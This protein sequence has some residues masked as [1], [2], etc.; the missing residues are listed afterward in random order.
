MFSA[1]KGYFFS[2]SS[3][4]N[5]TTNSKENK[6]LKSDISNNNIIQNP[7]K[8]T[9]IKGEK[10]K[11]DFSDEY[12]EDENKQ[13][14]PSE[15][16]NNFIL[17]IDTV[18][19]W[20]M[21][22]CIYVK[23]SL[24]NITTLNCFK[25]IKIKKTKEGLLSYLGLG[26]ETLCEMKYIAAFDEHFIYMINLMK[27]ENKDEKDFMKVIG[28]HY[29]IMKINSVEISENKDRVLVS[30]LFV[31]DNDV[32]NFVSKTKK[33]YFEKQ[34]AFKFL[35]NLKDYL[36]NY[37]IKITYNDKVFKNIKFN[38]IEQK[39]E[40]EKIID[41][42]EIKIDENK[43]EKNEEEK[44]QKEQNEEKEES[45]EEIED[46]GEQLED[47]NVKEEKKIE[48]DKEN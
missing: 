19:Y 5:Q 44:G 20:R 11:L 40:E 10:N 15:N 17:K 16:V 28:N 14:E 31:L 37:Q 48:N 43:D 45:E 35:K 34:V 18:D 33:L 42:K 9:I 21:A 25:F 46:K 32:D 6:P 1:I 24:V 38:E 41:T 36:N 7:E 27:E 3:N 29:D 39:K 2:D 13:T 8:K 47:K 23:N 12:D 4:N 22:H 30:I 26:N